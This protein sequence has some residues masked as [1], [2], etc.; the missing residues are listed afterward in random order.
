VVFNV[1]GISGYTINPEVVTQSYTSAQT[2]R[3]AFTV[4]PASFENILISTPMVILYFVLAIMTMAGV[5][6]WRLKHE[7]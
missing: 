4:Q 3:V 7:R 2:I 5:V 6:Y 1:W